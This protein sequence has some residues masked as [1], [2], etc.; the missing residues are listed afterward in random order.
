MDYSISILKADAGNSNAMIAS[1]SLVVTLRIY[2]YSG[3]TYTASEV[4]A[5]NYKFTDIADGDYKLYIGGVENTAKGIFH[6]SDMTPHFDTIAEYTAAAGVT[7]DGVL[8]KDSLDVSGIIDK[9]TAQTIASVKTFSSTPKM[10]A[11]AEKTA[12]TGVTIDGILLK[13]YHQ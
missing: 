10:D 2:P 9:T 7:I 6:L 8:L 5:G 4:S 11:I 3:T 13:D 12:A 1:S